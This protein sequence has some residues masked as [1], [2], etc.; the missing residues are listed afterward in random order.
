MRCRLLVSACS[1]LDDRMGAYDEKKA[2][3]VELEG[4]CVRLQSK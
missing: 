4:L 2:E 3:M 1:D